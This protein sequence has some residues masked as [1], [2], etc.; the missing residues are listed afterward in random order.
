MIN[1]IFVGFLLISVYLVLFSCTK[2]VIDISTPDTTDTAAVKF[3]DTITYSKHIKNT[4]SSHCTLCHV[5]GGSGP[6]DFTNFGEVEFAIDSRG[7]EDRVL[8]PNALSPMPPR[9]GMTDEEKD[10]LKCW[11]DAGAPNN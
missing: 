9:G 6:G 8:D 4:L 5:A 1:K 11:I 10:Q 7:L 3:C 2:E